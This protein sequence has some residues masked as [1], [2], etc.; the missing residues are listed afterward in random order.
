MMSCCYILMYI[1]G[2][3]EDEP[4]INMVNGALNN[5]HENAL[6]IAYLQVGEVLV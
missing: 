5:I 6:I 1:L 4:Q 2:C 3:F